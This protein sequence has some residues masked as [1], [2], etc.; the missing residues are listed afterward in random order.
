[1]KKTND[2]IGLLDNFGI[3]LSAETTSGH[4]INECINELINHSIVI[5]ISL[6]NCIFLNDITI[7]DENNIT[8]KFPNR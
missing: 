8:Y 4:K 6:N 7:N 5:F 1:M 2:I 3:D